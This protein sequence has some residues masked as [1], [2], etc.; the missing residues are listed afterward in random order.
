MHWACF[1]GLAFVLMACSA[2]GGDGGLGRLCSFPVSVADP[3]GIRALPLHYLAG[4][5]GGSFGSER[6]GRLEKSGR[7]GG[8]FLSCPRMNLIARPSCVSRPAA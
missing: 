8:A 5:L 4:P 6:S 3:T 7:S 2:A 1:A